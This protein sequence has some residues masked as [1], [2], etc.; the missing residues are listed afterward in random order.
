MI[1]NA[2]STVIDWLKAH[3][4]AILAG[5]LLGPFGIVAVEVVK[6]WDSIK[7]TCSSAIDAIVGFVKKMPGQF[8]GALS[9]LG[10]AVGGGDLPV[11]IPLTLGLSAGVCVG[12][13]SGSPVMLDYVPPFAFTGAVKKVL[14]DVSGRALEDEEAA[15]QACHSRQIAVSIAA[16]FS[17]R[18][19]VRRAAK[20]RSVASATIVA[21][22]RSATMRC[23][24]CSRRESDASRLLVATPAAPRSVSV[25]ASLPSPSRSA[26]T[27]SA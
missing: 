20:R 4:Q 11:T 12:S 6:H 8:V 19:A 5:I 17:S 14:V 2:A 26:K 3:W 16:S 21:S 1:V 22:N 9:S 15:I 10:K 13:D 25:R 27:D 23:C 24:S 18:S 7:K